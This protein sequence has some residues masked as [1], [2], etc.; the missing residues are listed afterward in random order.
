[1]DSALQATE[2]V[3]VKA[4]P[5]E[6]ACVQD[7]PSLTYMSSCEDMTIKTESLCESG[8]IEIELPLADVHVKQEPSEPD[9]TAA[10][11]PYA[12]HLENNELLLE[13]V[14]GP[15]PVPQRRI[16]A[17][18]GK[19]PTKKTS[20]KMKIFKC[21]YCKY[22]TVNLLWLIRH[23]KKHCDKNT[24]SKSRLRVHKNNHTVET[25]KC[26]RIYASTSKSNLLHKV[27]L[28]KCNQCS[29]ACTQ[30]DDLLKHK[31]VH[32]VNP[33]N[34][35]G[36]LQVPERK[37][38]SEKAYK[39]SYCSDSFLE[40]VSWQVH[41]RKHTGEKPFKCDQCSYA[42]TQI[43]YLLRHKAMHTYVIPYKCSQC[44]FTCTKKDDLLNHKVVHIKDQPFKCDKCSFATDRKWHLRVHKAS[45]TGEETYTCSTCNYTTLRQIDLANHEARH[46]VNRFKCEKC[47]FACNRQFQLKN[48]ERITHDEKLN[49]RI[50]T[51]YAH[52]GSR[53]HLSI[54]KDS[55]EDLLAPPLVPVQG[56]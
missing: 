42:G 31:I 49:K 51:T 13:P 8:S 46:T 5:P 43:N 41:E 18:Q 15:E 55:A 34:P 47:S 14:R 21:A 22:E 44:N 38:T 40:E 29:F 45:H 52:N 48:H 12:G 16:V 53:N 50:Q 4:E 19:T 39:C 25:F 54:Q 28:Y 37:D 3:F 7:V 11:G 24:A 2:A 56:K 9:G 17:A 36:N 6:D 32:T 23:T 33:G 35:Q 10:A 1:M 26:G 27:K 30:Q 20:A